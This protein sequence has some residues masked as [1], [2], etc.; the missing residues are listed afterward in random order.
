MCVCV[1]V[2]VC[3]CVCVSNGLYTI[4]LVI[5]EGTAFPRMKGET[6]RPDAFS[7]LKSTQKQGPV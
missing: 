3:V 4:I 5:L 1:C 6:E 7:I 2:R